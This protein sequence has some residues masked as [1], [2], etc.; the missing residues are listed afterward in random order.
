LRCII[1]STEGISTQRT[2][3]AVSIEQLASNNG[4]VS[5]FIPTGVTKTQCVQYYF[6]SD[7]GQATKIAM[8]NYCQKL[9]SGLGYSSSGCIVCTDSDLTYTSPGLQLPTNLTCT[10]SATTSRLRF[11]QNTADTT[12]NSTILTPTS[13]S[14]TVNPALVNQS[15]PITFSICPVQH[16][17][18]DSDV[19]GNKLYSDYFDQL[20]ADT[21]TTALFNKNL[22]IVNVPVNNTLIVTDLVAPDISK[23]FVA[24]INSPTLMD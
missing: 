13:A 10:A 11:L 5:Q 23:D 24:K 4:T 3:A 15:N 9:F 12:N 14:S 19:S 17:V 7:P 20:I 16:P 21:A 22:G 18:C 6:T 2:S 8:V 1:S